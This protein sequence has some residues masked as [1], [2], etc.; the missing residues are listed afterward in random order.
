[1]KVWRT[2][3]QNLEGRLADIG[4]F[5]DTDVLRPGREIVRC[6]GEDIPLQ[7]VQPEITQR[8]FR[9]ERLTM[10]QSAAQQGWVWVSQFIDEH[11]MLRHQPEAL[12]GR[13]LGAKRRRAWERWVQVLGTKE[14]AIKPAF[15]PRVPEARA[16]LEADRDTDNRQ[17]EYTFT[18]AVALPKVPILHN[19]SKDIVYASDGSFKVEGGRPRQR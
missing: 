4:M 7:L 14:G 16:R 1:M 8:W 18:E 10:L 2:I 9:E 13:P 12:N 17:A 5:I 19:G 15:D 3:I 6:S 11:G